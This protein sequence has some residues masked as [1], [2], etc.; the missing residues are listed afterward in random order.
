MAWV[1]PVSL[2]VRRMTLLFAAVVLLCAAAPAL[3]RKDCNTIAAQALWLSQNTNFDTCAT[4]FANLRSNSD[5][6]LTNAENVE[7]V[8]TRPRR[9]AASCRCEFITVRPPPMPTGMYG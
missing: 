8:S 7:L 3:G 4:P 1:G 2:R 5:F 6:S 9:S